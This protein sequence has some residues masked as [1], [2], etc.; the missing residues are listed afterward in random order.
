MAQQKIGAYESRGTHEDEMSEHIQTRYVASTVTTITVDTPGTMGEQFVDLL[1]G[2]GDWDSWSRLSNVKIIGTLN[3]DDLRT[4]DNLRYGYYGKYYCF[5]RLDMSEC[6]IVKGGG[7][8]YTDKFLGD[9]YITE[10][11]VLGPYALPSG[12]LELILPNTLKRWDCFPSEELSIYRPTLIIGDS[13]MS[14][15]LSTGN[16][17]DLQ[18]IHVSENNPYL[19]SLDGV[20]FNKDKS[21]LLT[22]PRCYKRY[23]NATTNLPKHYVVP[24]S[25]REIGDYAFYATPVTEIDIPEGVVS[26]GKA[27][28]FDSSIICDET[29]IHVR[30]YYRI[31][32]DWLPNSLE[33]IG[34]IAFRNVGNRFII[35]PPNIKRIGPDAF[36]NWHDSST[37]PTE[38]G[39]RT[40]YSASPVPPECEPNKYNMGPFSFIRYYGTV[41]ECLAVGYR[42]KRLYVPMGSKAAYEQAF[43][44]GYEYFE[45]IIEVEDVMAAAQ[46]AID[47]AIAN[48]ISVLE[49]DKET[50]VEETARYNLQG[51]LLCK[52]MKGWNIVKYSDGSTRKVFIK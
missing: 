21:I 12:D 48:D 35:L 40:L 18:N 20:L 44:W 45:E 22:H 47:E 10:D 31:A 37:L 27:A 33:Y 19:S 26:I 1:K 32:L 38:Y 16:L 28:F 5:T 7:S 4:M 34:A 11:N 9:L 51:Q 15:S 24:E 25:V 29:A 50:S 36:M 39:G 30:Y 43:G 23:P 49:E 41:D 2:K 8:Y 13:L 3:G 17:F 14:I 46:E 6:N 42:H 52:P